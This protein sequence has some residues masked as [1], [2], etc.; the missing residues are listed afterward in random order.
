MCDLS[1][2]PELLV[3]DLLFS[4]STSCQNLGGLLMI[5]TQK[6]SFKIQLAK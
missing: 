6:K 2:G 5:G 1:F 4:E 3:N